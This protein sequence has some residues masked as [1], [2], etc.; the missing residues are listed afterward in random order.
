MVVLRGDWTRRDPAITEYLTSMGA[1]GVP[2][3]AW[4]PAG[5]EVEQ[6]PQ[7]LTPDLLADRAR[8]S[9]S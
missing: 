3:Y 9:G 6:L 2:L 5:G 4:Y 8:R 1:A 7:V